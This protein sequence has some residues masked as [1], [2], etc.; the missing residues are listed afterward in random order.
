MNVREEKESDILQIT[1]IHDKAFR[2]HD[3][4][5]IVEN[6]RKNGNLKISLVCEMRNKLVGHIAYSPVYS[7]NKIIGLGLAPVAVLPDFQ[8]QGIG[9]TLIRRGNKMAVS[10]GFLKIFVLG[11]PDYY[12]RLGFEPAKRYNYFSKFDPEGN[13]FMILK[14]HIKPER[15]KT[16]VE[17]GKEF[18]FIR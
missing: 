16:D 3:E 10:K 7:K 18:I 4:G 13:H 5:K 1:N 8:K 2:G 6:L 17:Y 9:S 12:S 11:D 15:K 14:N